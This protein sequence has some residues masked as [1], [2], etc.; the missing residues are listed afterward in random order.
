MQLFNTDCLDTM[1]TIPSNTI[2]GIVIDPPYGVEFHNHFYDDSRE[3]VFSNAPKWFREYYRILKENSYM[4]VFVGV[5]TIHEWIQA[6]IDAGF[7]Y[8]NIVATRSFNNGSPTPKNNFGFQ[9]QPILVFS[10][11]KGKPFNNVDFIPT[12]AEWFKDKRNK[13]PKPYTYSYPNWIKTEWCFASAKSSISNL[14]PNQKNVDLIKF[15]IKIST[16]KGDTILD[17]F[18]GSGTTG[19]ACTECDRNFIGIEMDSKY[20]KVAKERIEKSQMFI[21][22]DKKQ[23]MIKINQKEGV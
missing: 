1:K 9:F 2:D 14:H 23:D 10:K 5:K 20:F 16:N 4:F 22:K 17:S 8:K 19:V 7:E 15:L 13:N 3:T 6:G 21:E 18:M 12:S 11:G